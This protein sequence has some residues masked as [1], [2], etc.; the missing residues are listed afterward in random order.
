M[1]RKEKKGKER[2]RKE[3]KGREGTGTERK[4][5][6]I[7]AKIVACDSIFRLPRYLLDPCFRYA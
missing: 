6:Y 4:I 5:Y 1:K 2:Q 7:V 3:K